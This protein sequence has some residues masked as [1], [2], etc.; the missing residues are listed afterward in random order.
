MK[1][2]EKHLKQFKEVGFYQSGVDG[3]INR[4][5]TDDSIKISEKVFLVYMLMY[6]NNCM[7]IGKTKQGYKRPL[8]YHRNNVMINVNNGISEIVKKGEVVRVL[9]REF[10]ANDQ[11][12]IE[13]LN[14]NIYSAYEEALIKKYNPKWNNDK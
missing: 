13:D 1:I 4:V 5:K 12:N 11:F 2:E 6:N 10:K 3:V 9:C 7:Y 8:G 14:L